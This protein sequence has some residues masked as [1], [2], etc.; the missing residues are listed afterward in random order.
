MTVCAVEQT[1][2]QFPTILQMKHCSIPHSITCTTI[3][4]KDITYIYF[5]NLS[6][7][8]VHAKIKQTF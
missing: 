2:N 8:T 5:D 4:E 7:L 1:S 3:V 6:T